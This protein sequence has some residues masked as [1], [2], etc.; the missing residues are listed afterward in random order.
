MLSRQL[1]YDNTAAR[2]PVIVAGPAEV[3][4]VNA[5]FATVEIKRAGEAPTTGPVNTVVIPEN[6]TGPVNVILESSTDLLT[7][8]PVLPGT[9]SS[10]TQ[11]RFFRVRAVA[12]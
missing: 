6:A 12:P 2:N 3:R 7:W 8:T 11:R 4:F 1:G 9:Y 5:G 10:S